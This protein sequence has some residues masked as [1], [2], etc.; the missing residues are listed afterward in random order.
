MKKNSVP[1]KETVI[2]IHPCEIV[3]HAI[4]S[5]LQQFGYK[6]LLSFDS[7]ESFLKQLGDLHTDLVLVHYSQH[8]SNGIIKQIIDKTGANV[9]LLASSDSYHKDSY[10]DILEQMAEGVTGFLDLDESLHTFISELDGIASGNLVVS[11]QFVKN[12]TQNS[13]EIKGTLDEL[14]SDREIEILNL[15]SK[16]NTNK[17]IGQELFISEHTAKVHL[18]NIL[19]KLDLKNRQQAAVYILRK[20]LMNEHYAGKK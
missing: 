5:L 2:L 7:C 1:K 13:N 18:G 14:L 12:L 4:V 3:R 8:K 20:R 6:I 9:T 10:Q 17:E 11:K 15:V 19:T 16:G